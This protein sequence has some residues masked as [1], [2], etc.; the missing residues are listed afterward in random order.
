MVH[1][2]IGK[3]GEARDFDLQGSNKQ[4]VY[5]AEFGFG[6]IRLEHLILGEYSFS[7]K[8]DKIKDPIEP[9]TAQ[10][11]G[12]MIDA[13]IDIH[14]PKKP[15]PEE[16]P[17]P[18]HAEQVNSVQMMLM[19]EEEL[20]KLEDDSW[21]EAWDALEKEKNEALEEI[22]K[23]ALEIQRLKMEVKYHKAQNTTLKDAIVTLISGGGLG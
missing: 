9:F 22:G 16:A 8:F 6:T 1:G 13:F 15:E 3:D 10:S 2:Y 19:S 21:D 4:R 14:A 23:L 5:S 12:E 11:V 17:E 18:G 7:I 20:A